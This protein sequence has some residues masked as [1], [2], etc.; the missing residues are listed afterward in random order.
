[1]MAYT[2][3]RV[4]KEASQ[5]GFQEKRILLGGILNGMEGVISKGVGLVFFL[6]CSLDQYYSITRVLVLK[7][8]DL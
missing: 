6:C 2:L 3:V 1:M 5:F 4:Q 8:C 7:N